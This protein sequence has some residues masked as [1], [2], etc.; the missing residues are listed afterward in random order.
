VQTDG[1][2]SRR[3][4]VTLLHELV[5]ESTALIRD[6]FRLAKTE[7]AEMA[8]AIGTGTAFVAIGASLAL[9]GALAFLTGL[10]LLVGDQW[11]PADLYWVAALLVLVITGGLAAWLAKRGLSLLSP[12]ELA[13]TETVTTLR[14]DKEW[15]KQQLT[16]GATSS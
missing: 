3:G 12:S 15:L 2:D 5:G 7:I 6:E 4:I 8:R 10:V 11:L 1:Q 16:S 14:E 13:P 9:L